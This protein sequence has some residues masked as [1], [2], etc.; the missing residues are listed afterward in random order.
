MEVTAMEAAFYKLFAKVFQCTWDGCFNWYFGTLQM[1]S[2]YS[3]Q[4]CVM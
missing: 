1:G 4:D 2:V 3:Y